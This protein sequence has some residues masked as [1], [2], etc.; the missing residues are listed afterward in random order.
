M[1]LAVTC[2]PCLFAQ[3]TAS[4][5]ARNEA[6]DWDFTVWL[7]ALPGSTAE[8]AVAAAKKLGLHLPAPNPFIPEDLD[9]KVRC[10]SSAVAAIAF[11]CRHWNWRF[12]HGSS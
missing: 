6:V 1:S 12:P 5:T 8:E 11:P 10:Y 9:M 3:P 7:G 4:Q 2:S